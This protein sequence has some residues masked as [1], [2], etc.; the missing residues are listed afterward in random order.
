[1]SDRLIS[2]NSIMRKLMF[3]SKGEMIPD[4]DCDNF[5]VT[6]NLGQVKEMIRNEPTAHDEYDV[7][8]VIDKMNNYAMIYDLTYREREIIRLFIDIVRRGGVE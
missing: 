4:H 1:M 3:T 7:E 5:P 6:I 8:A 2:A